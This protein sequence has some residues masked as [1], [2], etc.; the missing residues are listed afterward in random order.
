MEVMDFSDNSSSACLVEIPL[1]SVE[2]KLQFPQ[3]NFIVF[4]DGFHSSFL[5]FFF[6]FFFHFFFQLQFYFIF[7]LYKIVLVLPNIKINPPQVYM[8]SP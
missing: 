8:C 5:F 1:N 6:K 2:I 4:T 3:K 7:K